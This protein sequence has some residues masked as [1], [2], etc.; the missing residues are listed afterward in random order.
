MSYDLAK[1]TGASVTYGWKISSVTSGGPSDGKLR[2]GDIITALNNQT[3]RNNDDLASYLDAN[4]LPGA[5][6][7]ITVVRGTSSTHATLTLGL[8]PPP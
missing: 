8:R 3:V 1:Q 2:V 7:D 5:S 4:T 6:I